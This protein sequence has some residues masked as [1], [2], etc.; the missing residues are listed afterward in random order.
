[1]FG[2]TIKIYIIIKEN[3]MQKFAISTDSTSDFTA[4][5]IEK[6]GLYVGHLY[7]TLSENNK[8]VERKDNFQEIDEYTDFYNQLRKGAIAKTS[9]LN[10]QAH[11]DLFTKMAKN[12]VK[13]AIHITQA[14]GLSP[15]L[16]NAIA[17]ITEVKKEFPDI[18]YV[19]IES[20]TTTV[21]EGNLVKIAI[22]LRDQGKSL[23]ETISTL[24]KLKGKMQHFIVV[25]DLM[26]LKRGGRIGS[27]SA[28]LGTLLQIRPIIEFTKDGKLEIVKKEKGFKK[29]LRGIIDNVKTNY[30][31]HED[32][33]YPIIAH[34]DAQED[35]ELFAKMFEDEFNIKPEIRMIG[36]IIGAHLGPNAVALTFLS[37]EQRKY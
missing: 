28:V 36:P 26:Y 23:K 1:M 25:S 6:L 7:F 30:T 27:T 35:A 12:G 19:A 3:F 33:A 37:N 32:F 15:T 10:L 22:A 21:A 29:A 11:I 9:I 13:N 24:E 16:N 8:L 14:M 4:E 17:A 34:T 18:N 31:F 20:S 5:E 2:A